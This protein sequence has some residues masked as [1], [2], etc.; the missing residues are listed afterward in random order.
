MLL[1]TIFFQGKPL[2]QRD[3]AKLHAHASPQQSAPPRLRAQKV[4]RPRPK[5]I[6]V[7][8]GSVD[9]SEA[10]SL[11]SRGKKGSSTNLTGKFSD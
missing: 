11:S 7:E 8:S 6:H 4:T 5:T 3:Y 2:D 9:I 10:S 1:I